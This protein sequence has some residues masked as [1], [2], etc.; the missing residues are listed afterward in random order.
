MSTPARHG[1]LWVLVA[2]RRAASRLKNTASR[3]ENT[4]SRL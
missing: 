2:T 4:V 1:F 3:P